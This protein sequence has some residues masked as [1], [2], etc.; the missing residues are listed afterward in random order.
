[1]TD[2]LKGIATDREA[3]RR[4]LSRTPLGRIGAPEEV[5]AVAAFLA[6]DQA[7]YLTGQTIYPDGGRLG[8]NYVVPVK[9]EALE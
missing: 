2:I 4:L 3:K 7:S 6:S 8:L 1:M 5:A 9:D